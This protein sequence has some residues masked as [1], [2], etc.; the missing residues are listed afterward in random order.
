MEIRITKNEFF[1]ALQSVQGI[2]D[3]RSTMP[4]L[5]NVLI[6][7]HEDSISVVATDLQICI[8]GFYSARV[9][10]KGK[11]TINAKKTHDIVRELPDE[12]IHLHEEKDN[13]I[14][15]SCGKSDFNLAGFAPEDFPTLPAYTE[16]GMINL[17][18]S[19]FKNMIEKTIF[20]VSL[21][22]N[23]QALNGVLLK[24]MSNK[25]QMVATDGH[26]LA[27][28]SDTNIESLENE[29]SVLIPRKTLAELS[30]S[31]NEEEPLLLGIHE[32]HIVF[33]QAGYVLISRMIDAQFP[34]FE[35]VIPRENTVKL[36]VSKEEF[37]HALRRVSILLKDRSKMVKFSIQNDQIILT[38]EESEIGN[39]REE[40]NLD[41]KGEGF[42]VGFNARYLL[43]ALNAIDT[44]EVG[45]ELKD[46]LNP[47][48]LVPYGNDNYKCVIMPMRV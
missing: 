23:R 38:S 18:S 11:V 19:I 28:I 40:I 27:F 42:T 43:D 20:A 32:N 12:D 30:K 16:E 33:K 45:I 8:K 4:I 14:K 13:W 3:V 5:S 39:A 15:I 10:Q 6:E 46:S 26:R 35:Q 48:L 24:L 7:T 2:V 44:K 1:K 36:K 25:I 9:I 47:C 17:S 37:T 21:D 34:N 31:L 29:M 41:F 22:E